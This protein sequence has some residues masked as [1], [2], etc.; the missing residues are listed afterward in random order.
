MDRIF[1]FFLG[2]ALLAPPSSHALGFRLLHQDA[3]AVARGNSFVATADNASALY[4][5]PAG[6]TALRGQNIRASAYLVTYNVDF[7]A[8]GAETDTIDRL[9][10]VPQLYYTI[11]LGDTPVSLGLGAYAPYGLSS[12]WPKNGPFRSVGTKSSLMYSRVNPVV[13]WEVSE[14][15]SVAA[16]ATLNFAY[17]DLR[18]GMVVPNDQLLIYG[19]GFDASFNLG[20]MWRPHEQWSVG[21]NYVGPSEIGFNGETIAT[22]AD[23][24]IPTGAIDSKV[25]IEFPQNVVVGVSFRPTPQWN[26]EFDL[27]W[28]DWDDS[29][30]G[31]KSGFM[32][33]FGATRE[34]ANGY[35]ISAGYVFGENNIPDAAFT[36]RVSD[37]DYHVL[38][39]GIGRKL[40]K[41]DWD[42]AYQ[43]G[44]GPSRLVAGSAPSAFGGRNAD[45]KYE[46]VSH[47]VALAVGRAF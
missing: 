33:M 27:D 23:P 46:F 37:Y 17:L 19:K 1:Y 29:L 30:P 24:F 14:E 34:L 42:I 21:V 10:A 9:S 5:N 43:F 47:A 26:L 25:P 3:R 6:I 12:E 31:Y 16:G 38:S 41:W 8:P 28:T 44:W 20:L 4:Y 15:L 40:E 2:S 45:G 32:Y 7:S 39:A 11:K 22:G 36:P 18:N 35:A 13:A